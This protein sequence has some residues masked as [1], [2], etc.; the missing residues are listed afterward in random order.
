MNRTEV[1]IGIDVSKDWLQVDKFDSRPSEVANNVRAIRA[2]V[3]RLQGYG[4]PA[5]C[6]EATGGYERLLVTELLRAGIEVAVANPK[7]VRDFARSK[8][9]LAK[10]DKIDA[11]VLS[12]F[13]RQNRP[14]TRGAEPE[15][16]TPLRQLLV[17]RDELMAMSKQEK[18]RLSPAP[19]A[20]VVRFIKEHIRLLDKC[21]ATV[22]QKIDQLVKSEADLS[23]R[24]QRFTQVKAMGPQSALYLCAFVPELGR[25]SNN[26]AAALV[27]VAPYNSDSGNM[28]GR[29]S[30]Q[31][32]R[33][34][35]RKV[36]YMA[37]V[38][39]S[40]SNPIL[41]A[42]YQ[43]L[44]RRGKPPKVALVAVMRKLVCLANR[45]CAKPQFQLTQ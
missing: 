8:G 34:R 43:Q 24:I 28:K 3:K 31:G 10:T 40:R 32:G 14:R 1:Y 2:L 25:I 6:C 45:I 18:N 41:S 11:H 21:M 16:L 4:E 20:Q 22:T 9:I 5:I 38:S 23:E 35:V 42:Y 37:S 7:R 26:E 39:A 12:E 13:G 30:T 27:G 33:A 17:R 29:R 44:V 36:L 15:W 19:S